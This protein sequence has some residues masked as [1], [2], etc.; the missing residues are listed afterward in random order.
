MTADDVKA[1]L[2]GRHPATLPQRPGPGPWT[3][4]EEFDDI[5]FLAFSSWSSKKPPTVGYE[6]KVT[7]GDYRR[8]LLKPSKRA[9]A[10][11]KCHVFYFAVPAG[12]LTDLE[13]A[14]VEPEHFQDGSAFVR[15]KCPKRCRRRRKRE[16][17]SHLIDVVDADLR[18]CGHEV[19]VPVVFGDVAC[20]LRSH[21]EIDPGRMSWKA[22]R[23]R[24]RWVVCEECGGRGYLQVSVV[25]EEAPTLWIPRDVGLV[26]VDDHGLAA[27]A[28][29]APLSEPTAAWNLGKLVRWASYRPDRRHAGKS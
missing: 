16:P 28:R 22:T 6:V 2:R 8:E 9:T 11:A 29:K 15:E 3:C 21:V 12:L 27:V 14:Y 24:S 7:R 18:K 20:E 1:A 19:R 13:K 25:E 17:K 23:T 4:L 5:D 26:E 10:V